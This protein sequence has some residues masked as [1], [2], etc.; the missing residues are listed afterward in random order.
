M[1]AIAGGIILAFLIIAGFASLFSRE[2]VGALILWF[3]AF[4]LVLMF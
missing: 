4:L 1:M 3:L 2:V